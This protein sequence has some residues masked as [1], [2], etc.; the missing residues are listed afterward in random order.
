MHGAN[1]KVVLYI[2]LDLYKRYIWLKMEYSNRYC[3][4][5]HTHMHACMH[6]KEPLSIHQTKRVLQLKV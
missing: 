6:V 5:R 2:L 1:M 4:W 3:T